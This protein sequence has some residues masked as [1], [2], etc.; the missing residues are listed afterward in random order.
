MVLPKAGL[1]TDGNVKPLYPGDDMAGVETEGLPPTPIALQLSPSR[2]RIHVR[3]AGLG[4]LEVACPGCTGPFR[5]DLFDWQGQLKRTAQA[6]G[7]DSGE[8]AIEL[9]ILPGSLPGGAYL[10]GVTHGGKVGYRRLVLPL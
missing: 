5:V 4:R 1:Y 7:M 9:E 6:K 8:A 2:S 10:L 3:M